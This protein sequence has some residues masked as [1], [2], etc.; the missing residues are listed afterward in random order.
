[1]IK[2]A[3]VASLRLRVGAFGL[4]RAKGYGGRSVECTVASCELRQNEDRLAGQEFVFGFLIDRSGAKGSGQSVGTWIVGCG[5]VLASAF[6]CPHWAQY[7]LDLRLST[8]PLIAPSCLASPRL[9]LRLPDRVLVTIIT[10]DWL[11]DC[12]R[13]C[14]YGERKKAMKRSQGWLRCVAPPRNAS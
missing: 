3:G 2:W 4:G 1:M 10:W 8:T 7:R 11:A 6:L 5:C 9:A 14:K 13:T 12:K